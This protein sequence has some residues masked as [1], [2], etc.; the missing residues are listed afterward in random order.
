MNFVNYGNCRRPLNRAAAPLAELS[1]VTHPLSQKIT[2]GRGFTLDLTEISNSDISG[3]YFSRQRMG[4]PPERLYR[5]SAFRSL[6][7]ASSSSDWLLA[8]SA[9][10]Y[11]RAGRAGNSIII[12]GNVSL[13]PKLTTS[14]Q[15]G[16]TPVRAVYG[17]V[18]GSLQMDVI[19]SA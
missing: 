17:L 19:G 6:R 7:S 15:T 16:R 9:I 11:E 1:L 14:C 13:R 4:L 8:Q 10:V 2:A 18:V 3:Y 5:C 12:L